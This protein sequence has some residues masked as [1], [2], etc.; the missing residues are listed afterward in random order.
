MTAEIVMVKE[1]EIEISGFTGS[2]MGAAIG[3]SLGD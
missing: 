1:R 2:L 3:D